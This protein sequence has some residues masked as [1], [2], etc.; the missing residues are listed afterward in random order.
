MKR[1]ISIIIEVLIIFFF[2]KITRTASNGRI[3]IGIELLSSIL[4]SAAVLIINLIEAIITYIYN[5]TNNTFI[6]Y[7]SSLE[8]PRVLLSI[9]IFFCAFKALEIYGNLP[10]SVFILS[11]ISIGMAFLHYVFVRVF[12]AF[13]GSNDDLFIIDSNDNDEYI[14]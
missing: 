11:F 8:I 2:M 6:R 14:S 13:F 9:I 7:N 12:N 5:H 10:A 3:T 4:L 1:I